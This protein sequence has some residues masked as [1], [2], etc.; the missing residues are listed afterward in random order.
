MK[1]ALFFT[2]GFILTSSIWGQKFPYQNPVLSSEERAKD[3]ISRLTISEKATL[4]CDIS[5][6]PFNIRRKSRV[7]VRS[8]RCHPSSRD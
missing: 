8:I 7:D 3:L 2:L 5:D 6:N 1:K 4:M